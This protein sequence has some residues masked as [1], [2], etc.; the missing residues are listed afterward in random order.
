MTYFQ[1]DIT[2]EPLVQRDDDKEATIMSRL[3]LFH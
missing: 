1:D 3:K 2:G